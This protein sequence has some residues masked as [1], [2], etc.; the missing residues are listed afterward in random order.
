M[1]ADK[2]D[3]WAGLIRLP[4]GHD[5]PIFSAASDV[6][7]GDLL[8]GYLRIRRGAQSQEPTP[9]QRAD[10]VRFAATLHQPGGLPQVEAMSSQELQDAARMLCT[11]PSRSKLLD[12]SERLSRLVPPRALVKFLLALGLGYCPEESKHLATALGLRAAA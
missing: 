6:F 10:L 2:V 8:E 11:A 9:R 3:F 1:L 4:E 12:T 5:I 7:C